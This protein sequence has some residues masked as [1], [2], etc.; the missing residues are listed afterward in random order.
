MSA[1]HNGSLSTAKKIIKLA[2]KYGADAIKLQTYTPSS[3][4][5]NSKKNILK[6][7]KE[8]G[9]ENIFGIYTKK[10]K[11]HTVGTQSYLILQ[12]K[13]ILFALAHH[14]TQMLLNY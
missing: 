3:I 1:N 9:K 14:L 6:L 8:F 5:L 11:L 4:T 12:K 10:H 7:T 2:K 13:I